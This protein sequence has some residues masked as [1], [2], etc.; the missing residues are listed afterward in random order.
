MSIEKRVLWTEGLFLCPQTFQQQ[1]R[2]LINQI[3]SRNSQLSPYPWGLSDYA[4]DESKLK[5]GIFSLLKCNGIFP[6]GTPFDISGELQ[7]L[8]IDDSETN[9]FIYLA[10]GAH[11]PESPEVTSENDREKYQTRRFYSTEG[12]IS[13][14]QTIDSPLKTEHIQLGRLNLHLIL[15]ET[16]KNSFTQIPLAYLKE[17]DKNTGIKLS[18]TFIPPVL[19]VNANKVLREYLANTYN[20]LT[21]RGKELSSRLSTAGSGGIAE[22]IDFNMLQALNRNIPLYNFLNKQPILHPKELYIHLVKLAGELSTFTRTDR[23]PI[24]Y[25]DYIHDDLKTSFELL[26]AD[27][28]ESL[29]Y[30]NIP[31]S[32][33]LNLE[34]NERFPNIYSGLFPENVLETSKSYVLAVSSSLRQSEILNRIPA[35]ITISA[36]DQ[37]YKL[38]QS[39]TPGITLDSLAVCP[40]EIPYHQGYVYFTISNTHAMWK[41]VQETR[42][43]ALH[44]DGKFPDLQL[45]F[46]AIRAETHE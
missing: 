44:I 24:T 43:I 29:T 13:D 25:P 33:S 38:V 8:N 15:S 34:V 5:H 1:E 41:D 16:P 30:I 26:M 4:I 45:E 37:L 14:I 32:Y 31:K 18:R 22:I 11:H 20:L 7:E 42:S 27:L 9:K 6:D 40:R 35:Q 39:H 36:K 46:W 10:L 21:S 28:H 3:E 23:T 12:Q 2:Y 19:S 17:R